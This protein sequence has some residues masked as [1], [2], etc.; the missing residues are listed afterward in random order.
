MGVPQTLKVRR[1]I[2]SIVQLLGRGVSYLFAAGALAVIGV[3]AT[4]WLRDGHWTSMS[5]ADGVLWVTL[6]A[7]ISTESASVA[8]WV[9]NPT[10]W[11][12]LHSLVSTIPLALS[13]FGVGLVGM[14]LGDWGRTVR[15]NAEQLIWSENHFVA[16][17][18]GPFSRTVPAAGGTP[19]PALL[20]AQ[21]S[22]A[23][24]S[25]ERD[26]L[27]WLAVNGT[28]KS[29]STASAMARHLAKPVAAIDASLATLQR[30]QYVL[31][32]D[33]SAALTERGRTYCVGQGWT[34][35]S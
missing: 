29:V 32:S 25:L 21:L 9:H 17:Q 8:S 22:D 28:D 2:G 13:L 3:Q 26:I 33:H 35:R 14:L 24:H 10:T 7:P 31:V 23:S 16:H 6:R 27:R 5:T 1:S 12:G 20:E 18:V 11:L 34:M 19:S 15:F 4:D 30:F